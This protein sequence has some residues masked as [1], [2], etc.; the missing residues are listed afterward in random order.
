[1]YV[2]VAHSFVVVVVVVVVVNQ[3]DESINP[4]EWRG[5]SCAAGLSAMAACARVRATRVWRRLLYVLAS[6]A[7]AF[8]MLPAISCGRLLASAATLR[9]SS[10]SLRSERQLDAGTSNADFSFFGG[11]SFSFGGAFG[12]VKRKV[13]PDAATLQREKLRI[14][15]SNTRVEFSCAAMSPL[16]IARARDVIDMMCPNY[17]LVW[18]VCAPRSLSS[19]AGSL[20]AP[21]LLLL[22]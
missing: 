20:L 5:D 9:R 14:L 8:A 21:S 1:M 6:A 18:K 22:R 17:G 12:M 16:Y 2:K 3:K 19:L 7:A 10:S 11:L 15:R 4:R 13:E